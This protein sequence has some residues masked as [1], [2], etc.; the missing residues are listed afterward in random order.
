MVGAHNATFLMEGNSLQ[1]ASAIVKKA[2]DAGNQS[3]FSD[4]FIY[5][6]G[7]FI[8]DDHLYVNRIINIPSIDII[9]TT[10]DGRFASHWHTHRDNMDVID[11]RTLKAVG[12]TLLEVI[13][14]ETGV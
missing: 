5:K 11:H 8:T 7:G 4:Y 13:F 1:Y 12:Q 6:N 10:P 14:R 3:G 2:W 9:N